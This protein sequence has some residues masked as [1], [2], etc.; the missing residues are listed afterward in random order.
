MSAKFSPEDINALTQA[1]SD[2]L[3]LLNALQ[4]TE[5]EAQTLAELKFLGF[6]EGL[7]LNLGSE[8]ATS[9]LNHLESVVANW[10][11]EPDSACL[12]D[13]AADFAAIYLN[14]QFGA[15]PH[16][17]YWLDEDHLVMQKPMFEVRKLYQAH[18]MAVE[19]WR[20]RADDHI[21][22]ELNFLAEIV[23]MTGDQNNLSV[24]ATFLDEHLLR[25]VDQFAGRVASHSESD[26][27]TGLTLLTAVY[28]DELRDLLA[29]MLDEPR[30]DPAEIELKMR[31]KLK[32]AIK[33]APPQFGP[34]S[35][36]TF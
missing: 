20:N 27:Y 30:P 9:I 29:V 10:P 33:V 12:D 22:I 4:A 36:P 35:G 17:S 13:L 11:D 14:G 26:F 16:E 8:K 28:C 15:S 2:D 24:A 31:E 1:V 5:L 6:P 3:A 7:G 18:G 21:V 23:K 25:W 34:E 32:E 19:N